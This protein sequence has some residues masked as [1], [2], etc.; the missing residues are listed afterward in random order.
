MLNTA[1]K[2]LTSLSLEQK[3]N[4]MKTY[5]VVIVG[6]GSAGLSAAIELY[7][8]GITNILI[9]ERDYELGGILLQCIHNMRKS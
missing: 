1:N 6:G 2:V 8:E 4:K 5:D 3:E 7:K 9:I